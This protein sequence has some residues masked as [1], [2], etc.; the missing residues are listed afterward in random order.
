MCV[1]VC[2]CLCICVCVCVFVC[3][4]V[5]LCVCV[6]VCENNYA[7]YA[8]QGMEVQDLSTDCSLNS[9][10]LQAEVKY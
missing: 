10:R 9:I 1:C 8:L 6:C 2:V 5:Y 3:V 4:F 7:A